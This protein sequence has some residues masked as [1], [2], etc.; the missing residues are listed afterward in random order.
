MA[1]IL[2]ILI[3]P[4]GF[5]V[6]VEAKD[7]FIERSFQNSREGVSDFLAFAGPFLKSENLKFCAVSTVNESGAVM[8][9]LTESG[10]QVGFL[11]YPTY[12]AYA[13]EAKS[14]PMSAAT[15]A[16]CCVA[17]YIVTR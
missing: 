1:K 5:N 13:E 10:P 9:W 16:K 8:Q 6:A 17:R 3:L 14:D 12:K 11:T 7:G 4:S 2:A 15:V